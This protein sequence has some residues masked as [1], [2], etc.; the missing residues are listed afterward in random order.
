[1][2]KLAILIPAASVK[3]FGVICKILIFLEKHMQEFL[4][5]KFQVKEFPSA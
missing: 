2:G 5:L 1:V 3:G 4:Q